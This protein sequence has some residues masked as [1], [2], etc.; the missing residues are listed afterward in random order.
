MLNKKIN[1]P[2]IGSDETGVGDYFSPLV[3]AAVAFKK[4]YYQQI[5]ALNLKDSKQLSDSNIIKIASQLKRYCHYRIRHLSQNGYNKLI[6]SFNGHELKTFLHLNAIGELN[7]NLKYPSAIID[8][9]ASSKN[10]YHYWDKLKETTLEITN[11]NCEL[12]F[13]E[14]ADQKYLEVSAASILAR[15]FLLSKMHKQ[16]LEWNMNF[17]LGASQKVIEFGKD[18]IKK[19][20]K[21]ELSKVA[22]IHFKTT[23][24]IL[25]K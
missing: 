12:I 20:S 19:Y 7:R 25:T 3:V 2:I 5:L 4:E 9:F 23:E 16:N 24:A 21:E 10:F 6:K 8:Q 1:F 18:F 17:P 11:P 22:K 14:K 13:E 15:D